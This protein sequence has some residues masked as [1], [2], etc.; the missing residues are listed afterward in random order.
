MR[1][2]NMAFGKDPARLGQVAP[3]G[4]STRQQAAF[5]TRRHKSSGG[6]KLI[7]RN[8][9]QPSLY[10]PDTIRVVPGSF[11]QQFLD[12]NGNLV[13]GNFPFWSYLEH[14]HG[15][16]KKSAFCSGGVYRWQ[17]GASAPCHG[18]DIYWEDW[19]IRK[20]TGD[21]NRPKRVSMRDMFA[22]SV[23]DQGVFHEVEDTNQS[24]QVKINPGTKQPYMTWVKCDGPQCQICPL[25]KK[26]KQGHAQP[27][28]MGKRHFGT[29]TAFDDQIGLG[30]MTCGSRVS[31]TTVLWHCGNPECGETM[32]DMSTTTLTHEQLHDRTNEPQKC[33]R[34][35]QSH[36]MQDLYECSVCTPQG[37]SALR[38]TIF[39]V[40]MQ[41]RR[42]QNPGESGTQ[43]L[44]LGTGDPQPIDPA[45]S[46]IAKPQKLDSMYGPTDL[47]LQA[48]L[49]QVQVQQQQLPPPQGQVPDQQQPAP[50]GQA[51]QGQA[52][53]Q[54]YQ[55][56]QQPAPPQG[57]VPQQQ[58]QFQQPDQQTQQ[59]FPPQGQPPQQ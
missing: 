57:Q 4:G 19:N 9:F 22:Y 43:L 25:G 26:T 52:S 53:Q 41:V 29:L 17:K 27:W 33:P 20:S 18:C 31:V 11:W 40:D 47:N 37:V 39:D 59:G 48:K 10:V 23:V 35:Q 15:V 1:S 3:F 58:Q 8:Q 30:C 12:D 2:Y 54:P 44:I 49:F 45:F 51:P 14:F 7:F 42:Q 36:F 38:A 6:S 34:C 55:Q 28:P 46:E 16:F 24:G 13:E 56:Y 21:K 5:A 50:Q 32:I